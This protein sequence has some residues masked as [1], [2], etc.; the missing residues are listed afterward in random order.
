MSRQMID[1]LSHFRLVLDNVGWHSRP[2]DLAGSRH[3]LIRGWAKDYI[4]T[5][6]IFDPLDD[7]T[8]GGQES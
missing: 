7:F 6:N 3:E 1:P 5:G 2:C 4:F 8:D